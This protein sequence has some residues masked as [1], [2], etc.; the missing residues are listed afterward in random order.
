M[1][2]IIDVKAVDFHVAEGAKTG[3]EARARA[4]EVPEGG[5][6]LRSLIVGGEGCCGE[7]AAEA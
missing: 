3:V 1:V 2:L 7:G 5:S 4:K 6:E